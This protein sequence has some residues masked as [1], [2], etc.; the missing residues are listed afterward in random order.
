MPKKK[1]E[2]ALTAA[3]KNI[4]V[5]L[6]SP[7]KLKPF[8][9]AATKYAS[10]ASAIGTIDSDEKQ[11]EALKLI[12]SI[13]SSLKD[14]D[15]EKTSITRPIKKAVK[16]VEAEFNSLAA[17]LSA[18]DANLTERM[19]DYQRE[20]KRLAEEAAVLEAKKREEE[21]RIE[22]QRIAAAKA[23]QDIEDA[24]RQSIEAFINGDDEGARAS[25]QA[26]AEIAAAPVVAPVVAPVA[27]IPVK[28]A[29]LATKVDGL[30]AGTK[31]TLVI[32]SFDLARVEPRF[33]L[34]NEK[35]VKE[36]FRAGRPVAGVVFDYE[37]DLVI[38]GVK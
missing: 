17:P 12:A 10:E 1:E 15:N 33:L 2:A 18:L 22:A 25:E 27:P 38:R 35:A 29:D 8:G 5:E 26:A 24:R 21:A 19:R 13:R 37:D 9:E 3:E 30:A 23:A 31:R 28:K 34:L 11:A 6:I 14:I 32:R 16:D 36:E 4:A 7:E 20:K